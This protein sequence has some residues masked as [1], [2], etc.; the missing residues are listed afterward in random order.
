M[1][2]VDH[3]IILLLHLVLEFMFFCCMKGGTMKLKS[4]WIKD[5]SLGSF[6]CCM[7]CST[8]DHHI[9]YYFLYPIRHRKSIRV[10]Q[11]ASFR[12]AINECVACHRGRIHSRNR[13]T[14]GKSQLY[15]SRHSGWTDRAYVQTFS[16]FLLYP[17]PLL[18]CSNR[19]ITVTT[20]PCMFWEN[21]EN[22]L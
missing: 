21:H 18:L 19:R 8:I 14:N 15:Q 20:K 3:E 16:W 1:K 12:D 10:C 22:C 13:K 11:S 7:F 9:W 4:R 5:E 6:H 2:N 17:F